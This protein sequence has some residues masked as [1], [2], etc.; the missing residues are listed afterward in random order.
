[1]YR[2][3]VHERLKLFFFFILLTNK[4]DNIVLKNDFV[5]PRSFFC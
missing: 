1:M 5:N 4:K 2:M 3:S